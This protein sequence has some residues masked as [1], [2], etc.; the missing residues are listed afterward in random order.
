MDIVAVNDGDVVIVNQPS[1]K[2]LAN[3]ESFCTESSSVTNEGEG[4]EHEADNPVRAG[5]LAGFR[6]RRAEHAVA[7]EEQRRQAQEKQKQIKEAIPERLL[8]HESASLRANRISV[9]VVKDESNSYGVGL[10]QVPRT[11]NLV[12]I[13]ALV[14]EG[15]LCDSPIRKGD[16]LKSVDNEPVQDYRSVMLQLME[17]NG[18]VTISVDTPASQ[19]NPAMVQAFCRKPSP[20]TLMGIEF[21]VVEHSTTQNALC[22]DPNGTQEIATS[23]LLQI[24]YIDPA[25]FFANSVLTPGDFVLSING[26]PC[27]EMG[28]DQ[29]STMIMESESIVDIL[30]LN[31]KL[32]QQYCSASPVQRWL[33][34]ARR[35][36]VGALGGTMGK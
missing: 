19:S 7:R 36:G 5:P 34:R 29:A 32:A 9:T 14:K 24:K 10:A 16:I 18:P 4:V 20:Y 35:T 22:A 17:T 15:L 2:E 23:K 31:P 6:R 33:R 8:E 28:S 30:A 1:V 26:T 27:T 13:D 3:D 11:K 12:R 25:G 21:E